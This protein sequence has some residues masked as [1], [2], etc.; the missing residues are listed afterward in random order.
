MVTT[1]HTIELYL[2]IYISIPVDPH[3]PI[4]QPWFEHEQISLSLI[5]RSAVLYMCR[6]GSEDPDVTETG[7]HTQSLTET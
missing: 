6:I 2:I 5:G 3:P 4:G 7:I 1:P